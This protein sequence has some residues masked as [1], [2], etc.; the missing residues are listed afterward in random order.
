M[1]QWVPGFHA[2]HTT[3]WASAGQGTA[4]AMG[5]FDGVHLGHQALIASLMRCTQA[6]TGTA[7]AS[8]VL[9]FD[10]HPAKLLRPAYA[11]QLLEPI[12]ARVAHMDALGVDAVVVHP[13]DHATASIEAEAFVVDVL[14]HTLRAKHI[15]VGADFVF[16]HKQGGNVELLQRMGQE[17]GFTV[18]PHP[19]VRIDGMVASSTKVRE[20]VRR[21]A[22]RGAEDLLGRPY[23]LYCHP[24][25]EA[26]P[27]AGPWQP[28]VPE[29]EQMP[30]PGLYAAWAAAEGC[31]AAALVHIAHLEDDTVQSVEI[32]A[33]PLR[34]DVLLPIRTCSLTLVARLH[35]MPMG[36]ASAYRA[37]SMND[38]S[39]AAAL[40]EVTGP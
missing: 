14:H 11:P 32:M 5:I 2:W 31:R 8:V 1:A 26:G 19:Q 36:G 21:G 3:P 9:T 35:A 22:L 12:A 18:H 29:G 16:G 38:T 34:G 17:L 30:A 10:P 40:L 25:E 39:A 33:H 7:L 24:K 15:I 4:V 28:L 6:H 20:F 37:P 13:F 27:N 23:V